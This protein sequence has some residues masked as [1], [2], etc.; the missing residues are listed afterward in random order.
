M[1]TYKQFLF[2]KKINTVIS[3]LATTSMEQLQ[4]SFLQLLFLQDGG[5]QTPITNYLDQHGV[6]DIWEA[7]F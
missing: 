2:L 1:S 6:K 5:L 4:L 3:C 7:D